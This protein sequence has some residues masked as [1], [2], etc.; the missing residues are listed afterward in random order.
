MFKAFLYGASALLAAISVTTAAETR[1]TVRPS[2]EQSRDTSAPT[3]VTACELGKDPAKFAN[4]RVRV[5]AFVDYAFEDFSLWD[6]SCDE[7]HRPGI[8]V[9]YGGPVNSGAVYC[10]PGEGIPRQ[11]A[12]P[13]PLVQDKTF[14]EFRA[15]LDGEHDTMVRVTFTGTFLNA[16]REVR[17]DGRTRE[18]GYGHMGCCHLFVIEQ[19]ESFEPHTRKD[20]D[21]SASQGFY[22]GRELKCKQV[23]YSDSHLKRPDGSMIL[24]PAFGDAPYFRR[25]QEAADAGER[26]WALSDPQRVATEVLHEANVDAPDKLKRVK[27]DDHRIVYE[28]E[29]EKKLT[30][31]VVSRPYWL[32]QFA[33]TTQVTWVVTKAESSGCGKIR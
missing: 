22:E 5:T 8:W 12:A 17:D 28:W 6:P 7:R 33:R 4:A 26:S 23:G 14:D 32:S 29:H 27:G 19:V 24:G 2:Q 1:Q 31:V 9:T 13:H 3:S 30:T 11:G 20:L 10:C 21:Y 18:V 25:L 15:L 16:H